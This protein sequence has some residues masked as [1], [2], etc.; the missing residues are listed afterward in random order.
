[1]IFMKIIAEYGMHIWYYL[2]FIFNVAQ[3]VEA[4]QWINDVHDTIDG[5][6]Y[7][8][9]VEMFIKGD[10]EVNNKEYTVKISELGN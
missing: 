5:N 1:M 7:Q 4:R 3:R 2:V 10:F 8:K 6:K 9:W